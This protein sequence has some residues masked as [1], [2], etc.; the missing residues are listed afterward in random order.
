[1]LE[2]PLALDTG[3]LWTDDDPGAPDRM[4]WF[5]RPVRELGEDD[6]HLFLRAAGDSEFVYAG[7]AGLGTIG[8]GRGGREAGF[9]LEMRLPHEVWIRI[10]GYSGWRIEVN[11]QETIIAPGDRTALET[12]LRKL[13][14]G[15]LGHLTMTRYEEDS[16]HL[17]LNPDRGWLMY[18]RH[19]SDSGLYTRDTA[20]TNPRAEV[21]FECDCGID[22]ETTMNRT[23][24]REHALELVREFFRTGLLP[25]SVPW[26]EDWD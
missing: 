5:P 10:G 8:D 3:S 12:L 18:L 1:M 21:F 26:T 16:L 2:G 4:P 25:Q 6:H 19:P 11:H 15:E 24:S 17:Y 13:G 14:E 7:P 23:L 20:A 9:Y 22:L